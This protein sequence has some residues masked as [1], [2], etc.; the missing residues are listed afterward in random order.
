MATPGFIKPQV[1]NSNSISMTNHG[2]SPLN[3]APLKPTTHSAFTSRARFFPKVL[4]TP[5]K[6]NPSKSMVFGAI[7]VFLFFALAGA[8]N[9]LAMLPRR[10][11]VYFL[12][13][14]IVCSVV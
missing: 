12:I 14:F 7:T 13:S 10:L 11:Q 8:F 5:R 3:I 9:A 6:A 4:P 1:S 2:P